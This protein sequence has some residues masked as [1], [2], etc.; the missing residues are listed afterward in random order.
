[1]QNLVKTS[2]ET[3]FLQKYL[4]YSKKSST[5]AAIFNF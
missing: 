1:M 4:H 3:L 5:F 2:L